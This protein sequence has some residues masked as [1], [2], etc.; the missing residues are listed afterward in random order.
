MFGIVAMAL[1]A[2]DIVQ[3]KP[4]FKKAVWFYLA[5]CCI[6]FVMFLPVTT[7]AWVPKEYLNFLEFLPDWHFVNI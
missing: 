3:A 7:G 5:L 4:Q 2:K 1:A 6:L